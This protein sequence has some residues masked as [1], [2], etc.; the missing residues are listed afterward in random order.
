MKMLLRRARAGTVLGLLMAMGGG[1]GEA[2][3]EAP[4]P[5]THT[6]TLGRLLEMEDARSTGDGELAR[7]VRHPEPGIRRRAALA[8]GRI[9]DPALVPG[10]LDLMNDQEVE[11]RQMAAF[12]LGLLGDAA[13]VERLIAALADSHPIVRGRAAEA[14]GRIG[15][16]R[17]APDLARFVAKTTPRVDGSV[18]VRGDD[19]G[20]LCP[21]D[22]P[23]I[24]AP[25]A[26]MM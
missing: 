10:L 6:R 13:A 19:P 26:A 12:A 11:V 14:L 4:P 1:V 3:D 24:S 25:E 17:A 9:G 21:A 16:R 20:S 22:S 8:A 23:A 5:P 2:K 15:D 7:L 18:A